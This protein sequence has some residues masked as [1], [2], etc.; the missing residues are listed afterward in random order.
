MRP[1][2]QSA[3]HVDSD[4]THQ[5]LDDFQARYS[6]RDTVLH[7]TD[8]GPAQPALCAVC[9]FLTYVL[10]FGLLHITPYT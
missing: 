4:V 2:S 5:F 1:V 8:R 3:R 10:L 7:F 6:Y 9:G